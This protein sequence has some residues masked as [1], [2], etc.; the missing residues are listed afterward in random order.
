MTGMGSCRLEVD[1]GG[2]IM[3]NPITVASGTFAA[4]REYSDF[5][6]VASL[7]AVIVMIKSSPTLIS[8]KFRLVKD[9][10][11]ETMTLPIISFA[12][13]LSSPE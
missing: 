2:L 6:D 10:C 1:L 11:L 9:G 8:L 3:K 7:G 5:V 4:G 13:Y 12:R